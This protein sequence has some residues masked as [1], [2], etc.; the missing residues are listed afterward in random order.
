MVR[1]MVLAEP[2][3]LQWASNTPH[4][5]E[6]YREFMTTTHLPAGKAFAAGNDEG[7]LRILIDRFDGPGTFDSLPPERRK[8]V[9]QNARFFKAITT[10]SEPFPNLSREKVSKLP[11]PVLLIRGEHTKDLDKL[12]HEELAQTIPN[13]QRRIIPNA[14]HGSPRQNPAAFNAAVLEFLSGQSV[15]H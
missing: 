5:A 9:M 8:I 14:G 2:P 12:V 1:S 3:V 10:S 11:M 7:A 15:T 4:G 6:L 13:V